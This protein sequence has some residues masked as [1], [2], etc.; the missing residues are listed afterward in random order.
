MTTDKK[1]DYLQRIL[2]HCHFVHHKSHAVCWVESKAASAVS[3]RLTDHL[4]KTSKDKNYTYTVASCKI[5]RHT[6]VT[7]DGAS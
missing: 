4:S 7:F 3:C 1:T 2:S 6:C 5:C